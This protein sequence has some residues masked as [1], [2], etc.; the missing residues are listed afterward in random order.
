[1]QAFVSLKFAASSKTVVI[2]RQIAVNHIEILNTF[3]R[4]FFRLQ[5]EHDKNWIELLQ[6]KPLV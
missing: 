5:L 1:M 3:I 4:A 6:Q 2:L